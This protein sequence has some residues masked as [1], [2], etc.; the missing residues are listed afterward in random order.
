MLYGYAMWLRGKLEPTG[1]N[2]DR[3]LFITL[4]TAYAMAAQLAHDG[5]QTASSSP[6]TASRR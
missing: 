1:T 4:P 6:R 2:F 5:R 3:S